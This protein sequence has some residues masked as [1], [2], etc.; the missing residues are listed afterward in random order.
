[1]LE[2]KRDY[3]RRDV[4]SSFRAPQEF[5][6]PFPYPLNIA[7]LEKGVGIDVPTRDAGT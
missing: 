4:R 1:M 6:K 3:R 5:L 2:N 7:R